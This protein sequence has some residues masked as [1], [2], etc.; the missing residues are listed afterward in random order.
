MA[1]SIRAIPFRMAAAFVVVVVLA[2]GVVSAVTT[3]DPGPFVGC[4]AS[5]TNPGAGTTK[6]TV[7]NVAKSGPLAACLKGDTQ[8]TF[9]N[10]QGPQGPQGIQ[11][12][13]GLQGTQGP[14]GDPGDSGFHPH[15]YWNFSLEASAGNE[16]AFSTATFP[17]AVSDEI[18]SHAARVTSVAGTAQA[19]DLPGTPANCAYAKIRITISSGTT[20][21]AEFFAG[22][23]HGVNLAGP[24]AHLGSSDSDDDGFGLKVSAKCFDADDNAVDGHPFASGVFVFDYDEPPVQFDAAP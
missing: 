2:T 11:G 12:V 18:H 19:A 6:G 17:P 10:A 9:S 24:P 4:L 7:Y 8:I 16:S 14:K 15:Q 23:L 21:L 13:Q 20:L 22:N 5:K 3:S 1:Q